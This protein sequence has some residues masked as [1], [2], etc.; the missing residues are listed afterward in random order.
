MARGAA[1]PGKCG[2]GKLWADPLQTASAE[3]A[4]RARR[5]RPLVGAVRQ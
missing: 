4:R 2:L 5:Y 3:Q 1:L